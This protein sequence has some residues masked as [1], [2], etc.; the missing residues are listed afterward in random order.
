MTLTYKT[1]YG[2]TVEI[3]HQN[4]FWCTLRESS[5]KLLG[6]DS[7]HCSRNPNEF[8]NMPMKALT[9]AEAYAE[10]Q[11]SYGVSEDPLPIV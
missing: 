1:T 8:L 2:V 6:A 11:R 9:L 10:A 4:G 3:S 7:R 5:G